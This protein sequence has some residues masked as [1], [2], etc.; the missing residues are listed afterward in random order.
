MKGGEALKIEIEQYVNE[1]EIPT[2]VHR[3][4][5]AELAVLDRDIEDAYFDLQ[6][7]YDIVMTPQAGNEVRAF[8]FDELKRA[9]SLIDFEEDGEKF[10]AS[11]MKARSYVRDNISNSERFKHHGRLNMVG[12]S[13]LDF[14][15]QWDY[16]EFLRKIGRTHATT[17]NMMREF[18]DYLFCQSQMKLYEDLQ[19]L[20]PEIYDRI[21][22]RVKDGRWEVI[23]GMYVEPDCNLISG[24]SFVRQL[25]FG[26]EFARREFG[27]THRTGPYPWSSGTVPYPWSSGPRTE[28]GPVRCPG[29]KGSGQG[30]T[31]VKVR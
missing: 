27:T 4:S 30:S 23:G 17:L 5:V 2:I 6:C 8:L 20:Y 18:P 10:R 31:Q 25:Q 14:V 9:I 13:H 3:F 28:G 15:Y 29:T 1:M 16:S 12:H 7:A 22:E 26:R 19:S 11:V 24:E 21:K